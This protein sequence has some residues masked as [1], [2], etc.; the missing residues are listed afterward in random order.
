M[1]FNIN[2]EDLQAMFVS[3]QY[4]KIVSPFVIK[5]IQK[6]SNR[7]YCTVNEQ[8]P[9]FYLSLTSAVSKLLPAPFLANWRGELGNDLADY[10]ANVAAE[11]GT[12]YHIVI[13]DFLKD[14]QIDLDN[15]NN[16][17]ADH[18]AQKKLSMDLAPEWI[19]K[20]H[21]DMLSFIQFVIDKNVEPVAIEFP[22]VSDELGIGTLLDLVCEMDFNKTRVRA[23]IDHKSGKKG[24][25]D[26][27]EL[28]LILGKHIWNGFYREI[29]PITHIFN[30]SPTEWRTKPNY[31][32]KNQTKSILNKSYLGLILRV[33]N[34]GWDQPSKT[35]VR[36]K[37]VFKLGQKDL[38]KNLEIQTFQDYIKQKQNETKER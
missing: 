23:L 2:Y 32:L 17:V 25:Y 37:G 38:S 26:S 28:Q 21:K 16:L 12:L 36:A 7:F 19:D 20:L 5:R 15:L 14:G 6:G 22:I 33:K 1:N 4:K 11:Y 29:F 13:A 31:K 34:E 27:H 8:E 9:K 18:I 10:K 3:P 30:F 35:I 24:F